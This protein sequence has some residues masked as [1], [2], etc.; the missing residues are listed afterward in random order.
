MDLIRREVLRSQLIIAIPYVPIML[1]TLVYYGQ[2][3][4]DNTGGIIDIDNQSLDLLFMTVYSLTLVIYAIKVL[5]MNY[6]K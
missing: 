6:K 1:L 5:I 3:T 4:N 2:Y